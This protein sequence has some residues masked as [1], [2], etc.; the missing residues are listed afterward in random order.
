MKQHNKKLH[1]ETMHTK[2]SMKT[3]HK[4]VIF[5]NMQN[6]DKDIKPSIS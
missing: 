5:K 3:Q 6:G 2:Q 4:I 1:S